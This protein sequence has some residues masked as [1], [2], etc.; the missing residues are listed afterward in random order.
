MTVTIVF[1]LVAMAVH[2]RGDK[3]LGESDSGKLVWDELAGIF[4]AMYLIPWTWKTATLGFF[5]ERATDTIKPPP[6]RQIDRNWHSGV[7]VVM[8]DVIAGIYTCIMLHVAIR[9]WP[10]LLVA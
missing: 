1:T 8:D 5:L 9:W 4:F 6:A 2:D 3:L 10:N 7:G